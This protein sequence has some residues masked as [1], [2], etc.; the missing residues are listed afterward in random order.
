LLHEIVQSAPRGF[1]PLKL[2]GVH[3]LVELPGQQGVDVGDP[4]INGRLHILGEPYRALHHLFDERGDL[5]AR[6]L[7]LVLVASNAGL[8]NDLLKEIIF[9]LLGNDSCLL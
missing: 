9:F 4:G 2:W 3:N 1:E 7:A 6:L 5:L 8:G